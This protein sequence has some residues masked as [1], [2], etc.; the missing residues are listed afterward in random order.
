M[1]VWF[2]ANREGNRAGGAIT[3]SVTLAVRQIISPARTAR[4][5]QSHPLGG[6]L[7]R[8]QPASSRKPLI[9]VDAM[10][11][12]EG[13]GTYSLTRRVALNAAFLIISSAAMAGADPAPMPAHHAPVVVSPGSGCN[14]CGSAPACGCDKPK[15]LEKLK[16]RF[17][18]PSRDCGCAPAACP[19]PCP[20]PYPAPCPP[21]VVKPCNP[22]CPQSIADRPNLLDKLKERWA[23][24]NQCNPCA[25][26]CANPCGDPCLNPCARTSMPVPGASLLDRPTGGNTSSIPF[27]MPP[28]PHTSGL[29]RTSPYQ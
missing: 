11:V 7:Q 24:K 4:S 20:T 27:P 23:S 17:S 14:P 9:P 16:G 18:R 12:L 22:C 19:A 28:R 8:F 13:T 10:L 1:C 26:P 15:L 6:S 3:R 25:N 5:A 21:P 29:T 2:L